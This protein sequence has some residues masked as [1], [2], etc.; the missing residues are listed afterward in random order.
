VTPFWM[1]PIRIRRHWATATC[2]VSVPVVSPDEITGTLNTEPPPNRQG[3]MDVGGHANEYITFLLLGALC[4]LV[5]GWV[6]F[7]NGRTSLADVYE[8]T[9][10]AD[11][12]NRLVTSFFYLVM[13]GVLA[14][15]ATLDIGG[16]S[17]LP[18]VVTKLGVL[19]L[20]LAAGHAL[21]VYIIA[22]MRDRQRHARRSEDIAMQRRHAQRPNVHPRP[23]ET[24]GEQDPIPPS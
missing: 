24:Y 15:V 2:Q 6:V 23:V 1:P 11:A 14:L 12:A 20:L 8:T 10:A 19:L 4:V 17:T 18:R 7:R 3:V 22:T 13:F 5:D 16:A 9:S 21:A